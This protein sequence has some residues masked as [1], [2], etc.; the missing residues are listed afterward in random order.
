MKYIM[1]SIPVNSILLLYDNKMIRDNVVLIR[2][3]TTTIQR[4]NFIFANHKGLRCIIFSNASRDR[5]QY[6]IKGT[7]Y[8]NVN[9]EVDLPYLQ[10]NKWSYISEKS[11]IITDIKSSYGKAHTPITNIR[12]DIF[13]RIFNSEFILE[14]MTL[15][16]MKTYNIRDI[17]KIDNDDSKFNTQL[18]IFG[19]NKLY[20]WNGEGDDILFMKPDITHIVILALT[21]H[22]DI[23][24]VQLRTNIDDK[25]LTSDK[26][27]LSS[28]KWT[29]FLT[30]QNNINI[31]ERHNN[32]CFPGKACNPIISDNKS[33][34]GRILIDIV[35]G[36]KFKVIW[37]ERD[38]VEYNS[39]RISCNKQMNIT[40]GNIIRDISTSNKI[41]GDDIH[42]VLI[43]IGLSEGSMIRTLK[44]NIKIEDV[45]RGTKVYC[46]GR[47]LP[48]SNISISDNTDKSLIIIEKDTFGI[49]IPYDDIICNE[50]HI[51]WIPHDSKDLSS[52]RRCSAKKLVSEHKAS[53]HNDICKKLYNLQ[54]DE[55]TSFYVNDIRCD[56]LS[57]YY[58]DF[59]LKKCMYNDKSKYKAHIT[60]DL[61]LRE[62]KDIPKLEM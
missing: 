46:D 62:L 39:R 40:Y 6:R 36:N 22:N 30:G 57:P 58:S 21:S 4:D 45:I 61:E 52:Y 51:F 44:G 41:S 27:S 32:I 13:D 15:K 16:T 49:D 25:V 37:N 55:E 28:G 19:D 50:H 7:L 8:H 31:T 3:K 33:V 48:V 35:H 14:N 12:S 38:V 20:K 59:L 17:I 34:L 1:I 23:E 60:Y 10:R 24:S 2:G 54:F 53:Y 18:N 9:F 42:F 47:Y 43:R 29:Y 26:I 56:A 11:F 5:L